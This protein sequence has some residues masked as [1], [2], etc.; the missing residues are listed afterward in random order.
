[1]DVERLRLDVP[2]IRAQWSDLL[3]STGLPRP[4]PG[5]EATL[6][7]CLGIRVDG[8]LIATGSR[9]AN[10]IQYMAILP[11][12]RDGGALF[13]QLLTEL[14]QLCSTA[15]VFHVFVST[16]PEYADSF[17]HI[18]FDELAR[19]PRGVLLETGDQRIGTYLRSLRPAAARTGERLGAIVMHANPFTLG[20]RHLVEAA[21]HDCDRV[22]IFVLTDTHALFDAAVRR[23]LVLAGTADLGQRVEVLPGGDYVVSTATFPA[24][25]L[26]DSR[27]VAEYQAE[28]DARIFRDHIAPALG[29]S[30]RFLGEE[31]NS[32]TTA[33][34]NQVLVRILSDTL[35]VRI[36]PRRTSAGA[37][38]SASAVREQIRAGSLTELSRLV[39]PSTL[40]YVR[41]HLGEL[42][43]RAEAR[44][45]R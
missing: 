1:M 23:D 17:V 35:Q 44:T 36:F 10:R 3:V 31:P 32:P 38:I 39:P 6:D 4:V 37:P 8:T 14:L 7:D 19:T 41:T 29:I 20:H 33:I 40:E 26:E 22:V 16:K 13:N 28:L 34:Y 24:Y 43:A 9:A 42:Q 45:P 11:R 21:L 12:F 27:Q 2:D 15:G 18:G 25:F 30:S 5:A